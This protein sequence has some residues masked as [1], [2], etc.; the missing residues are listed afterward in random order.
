MVMRRRGEHQRAIALLEEARALFREVGET[1]H[2]PPVLCELA[3]A[4]ADQGEM[5]EAVHLYQEC[6][7]LLREMGDKTQLPGWFDG[8]A[9]LAAR[10]GRHERV[11]R[12]GGVAA[13]LRDAIGSPLSGLERREQEEIMGRVRAEIGEE[14][15]R[16]A[17]ES[18]QSMTLEEAMAYAL[19]ARQE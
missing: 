6:G 12:L 9:A 7:L 10:Q 4:R 14:A 19:H 13:A 5:E 17:W 2:L 8:L 15:W 1:P 16:R 3:S 11:I 18:G